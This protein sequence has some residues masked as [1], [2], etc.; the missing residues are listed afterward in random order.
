MTWM[1]MTGP[2]T[3]QCGRRS[4]NIPFGIG[5]SRRP[6]IRI[7]APNERFSC[8]LPMVS[9]PR[10]VMTLQQCFMWP[11]SLPIART[12][13]LSADRGRADRRPGCRDRG[14][15]DAI[16]CLGGQLRRRRG[17]DRPGR[18]LVRPAGARG[19]G[20]G[21]LSGRVGH[22]ADRPGRAAR[23]AVTSSSCPAGCRNR[24]GGSP[25]VRVRTESSC[26]GRTWPCHPA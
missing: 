9:L 12:I 5:V 10:C 17:D 4:V 11:G 14:V 6:R 25:A 13:L 20:P 22:L 18:H 15:R 21:V 23:D 7:A 8:S 1:A 26:C 2:L 16:P 3:W 24:G 19:D